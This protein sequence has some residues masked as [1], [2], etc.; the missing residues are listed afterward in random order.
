MNRGRGAPRGG[1]GG[2]GG[3]RGGGRGGFSRPFAPM[4]PPDTVVGMF[5]LLVSL[6]L[7]ARCFYFV[8]WTNK[9]KKEKK[10][11]MSQS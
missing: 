3:G 9:K 10:M 4:G 2:F 5:T 6:D 11:M 1:R 7:D 8:V